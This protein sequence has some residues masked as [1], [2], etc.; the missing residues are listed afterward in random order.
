MKKIEAPSAAS[1]T[2]P[3][4]PL[5]WVLYVEDE[6]DNW[7]VTELQLRRRF[8]L[9]W[10]RDDRAACEQLRQAPRPP[11]AILMDIQL[12]G[13]ALDGIQLTRALRG[14]AVAP[15][16]PEYARGLPP[17]RAPIIFVTAYGARYS[18]QELLAAGG[19]AVINKPVD[20]V[21]LSL[22]LTSDHLQRI[23]AILK[24]VPTP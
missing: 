17:F 8:Q 11:H 14:T 10:A 4:R 20:F 19:S 9:T 15:D 7:I 2:P 3:A 23:Q 1:L 18:E 13:A 12:R 22:A 5:P 6:E 21:A 24:Q 16:V